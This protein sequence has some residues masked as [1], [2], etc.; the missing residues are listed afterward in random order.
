MV[1]RLAWCSEMPSEKLL[2]KWWSLVLPVKPSLVV[3]GHLQDEIPLSPSFRE[4]PLQLLAEL[5]HLT[6]KYSLGSEQGKLFAT[7]PPR[8]KAQSWNWILLFQIKLIFKSGG[9]SDLLSVPAVIQFLLRWKMARIS[10]LFGKISP[11]LTPWIT[12][13]VSYWECKIFIIF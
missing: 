11:H 7:C 4:F 6:L 8:C 9:E 10:A 1:L 3:L 12:A 2:N 13:L 5:D